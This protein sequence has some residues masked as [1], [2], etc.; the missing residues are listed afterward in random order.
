MTNV[1]NTIIISMVK[2]Y[3]TLEKMQ[4][5]N[6][7]KFTPNRL[8]NETATDYNVTIFNF[9]ILISL[10]FLNDHWEYMIRL[11]NSVTQSFTNTE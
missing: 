4:S 6:I 5:R 2:H 3:C 8:S 7:V 10:L 1:W 11:G 9:T